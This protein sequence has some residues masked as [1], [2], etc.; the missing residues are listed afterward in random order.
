MLTEREL[1]KIFSWLPYRNDWP[2]NPSEKENNLENYYGSLIYRFTNHGSFNVYESQDGSMSNFLEFICY[3][4]QDLYNGN[5]IIVYISLCA[6]VACYGQTQFFRNEKYSGHNFLKPESVG[7]VNDEQL[8]LIEEEII[9]ILKDNDLELISK[10]FANRSLPQEIVD[11]M[12]NTN[13]NFGDRY[14]HGLFQCK[15]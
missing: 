5:A 9:D 11:K 2:I 6:P 8:K 15:G 4:R 14:L 10:E 13:L 12:K 1:N 7:I 3:P